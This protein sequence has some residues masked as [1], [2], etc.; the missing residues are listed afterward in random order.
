MAV[1][2]TSTVLQVLAARIDSGTADGWS[3]SPWPSDLYHQDESGQVSPWSGH[4]Y[5]LVPTRTEP[6]SPTDRSHLLDRRSARVVVSSIEIRWSIATAIDAGAAPYHAA[7]ASE[8]QLIEAATARD[9]QPIRVEWLG[10]SRTVQA[11][12][13]VV[14]MI[15]LQVHH[16]ISMGV[17]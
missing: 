4:R 8:A 13:W 12:G 1:T 9:G 3:E 6:M 7:L 16:E 17:A 10:S 15:S 11:T 2:D 5:A 14:G